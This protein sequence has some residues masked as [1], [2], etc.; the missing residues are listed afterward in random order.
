VASEIERKFL[1]VDDS[2]LLM[3][4][5]QTDIK[6]GYL[7][8]GLD[9]SIRVRCMNDTGFLTIKG[10][11]NPLERFEVEFQIPYQQSIELLDRFCQHSSLTKTRFTFSAG[12]G[13]QWEIDVFHGKLEGLVLAE[14]ELPDAQAGFEKP[15]WVGKEVTADHRYLNAYLQGLHASEVS[16]LVNAART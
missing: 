13:L 15:S 9:P 8:E 5:E 6:Q 11:D 10:G 7:T 12:L 14:I 3:S 4:S 16:K 1:V 2:W